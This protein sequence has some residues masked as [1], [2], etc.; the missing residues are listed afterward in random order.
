MQ[1]GG[2]EQPTRLIVMRVTPPSAPA[3]PITAYTLFELTGAI[4]IVLQLMMAGER[5]TDPKWARIE[6]D[7]AS[8]SDGRQVYGE[9]V[10]P[11]IDPS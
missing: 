5:L 7:W 4:D 6:T 11:Q 1:R 10:M 3:A 2:S 9:R 8:C